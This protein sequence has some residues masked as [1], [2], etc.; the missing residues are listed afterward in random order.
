MEDLVN[1]DKYIAER[2]SETDALFEENY[3]LKLENEELR[4]FSNLAKIKEILKVKSYT[5]VITKNNGWTGSDT[6]KI[7]KRVIEVL[8][9]EFLDGSSEFDK[10]RLRFHILTDEFQE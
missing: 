9:N 7:K 10:L 2:L 6:I 8:G 5:K 1:T 4:N 3:K